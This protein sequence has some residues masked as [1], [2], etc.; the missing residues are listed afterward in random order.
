MYHYRS[1]DSSSRS[2][3]ERGIRFFLPSSLQ[4]RICD[5]SVSRGHLTNFKT[6]GLPS[7]RSV[8]EKASRSDYPAGAIGVCRAVTF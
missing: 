2:P 5:R 6:T 8:D 7:F 3:C 1:P 4:V